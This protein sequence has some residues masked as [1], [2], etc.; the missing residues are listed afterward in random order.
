MDDEDYEEILEKAHEYNEKLAALDSPL[1]NYDEIPGYE[2]ILDV[3][4]TGIMGYISIPQINVEL[5]IYHGTSSSVLNIA[6]GHM[7]GTSLPVGGENT[8][9]VISAHRGLPSAKL[10]S[11]LDELVEGDRFTVTVLKDVYTY[12]V[13]QIFIVLPNETQNLAIIPGEDYITLTTCTPYGINTHR[14][15]V[16]A[17]RVDTVA[18]AAEKKV[19]VSPDAVQVDSMTVVP[20]IAVPLLIIL[21]IV[22]FAGGKKKSFPHNDP[23]SVLEDPRGSGNETDEDNSVGGNSDNDNTDNYRGG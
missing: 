4:G 21:M 10:F 14:L 2:D 13:E 6:V 7:Q 22:W 9:A 19:R 3:S 17:H 5:P 16:R 12:E 18:E 1:V 23:L 20:V 11:D 8:H 15:L